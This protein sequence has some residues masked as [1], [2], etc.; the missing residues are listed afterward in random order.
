MSGERKKGSVVYSRIFFVY[1][2]SIGC[3]GSRPGLSGDT[4]P[5]AGAWTASRVCAWA[6][7]AT[8]RETS[9][10]S[11]PDDVDRRGMSKRA[12]GRWRA[13]ATSQRATASRT[14]TK[15]YDAH[16]HS[17][18]VASQHQPRPGS[19]QAS[20]GARGDSPRAA[21]DHVAG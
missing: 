4:M 9:A 11:R 3:E 16:A 21:R 20:S 10:T 7:R 6:G 8:T 13:R 1:S 5:V 19:P 15:E 17:A 12:E 18:D 14:T 2:S